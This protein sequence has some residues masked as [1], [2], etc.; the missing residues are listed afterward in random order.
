MI[1]ADTSAWME[2][3]RATG[4]PVDRR[5]TTLVGQRRSLATT[6][7]VMME[8]LA[9][10]PSTSRPPFASTGCAGGRGSRR[11]AWSTA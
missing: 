11:G 2:F 6:E 5:L 3:D 7:P 4:S 9:G 8:V 10:A 1:L